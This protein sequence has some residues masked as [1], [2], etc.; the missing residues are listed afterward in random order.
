MPFYVRWKHPT[1]ERL[2]GVF[3]AEQLPPQKHWM[4]V[5]YNPS[6]LIWVRVED[7]ETSGRELPVVCRGYNLDCGCS[8]ILDDEAE[9]ATGLHAPVCWDKIMD[10]L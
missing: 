9:Q 5:S 8:A 3:R 1:D 7:T 6:G 2:T 10:E 4:Y